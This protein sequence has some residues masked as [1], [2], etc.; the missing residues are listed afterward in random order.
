M[1]HDNDDGSVYRASVIT[2][3]RED[4]LR[5][6]PKGKLKDPA[7]TGVEEFPGGSTPS[8]YA[9]PV[10]AKELQDLIEHREM[11]FAVGNIFKACYRLGRK[12]GITD[13]YD[14]RKILFFADRELKRVTKGA[15]NG[16][17]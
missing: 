4:V 6:G 13:E 5:D 8:Q 9:L 17:S 15:E 3:D 2:F 14:L 11:N 7:K 10:E 1:L 12:E 16:K